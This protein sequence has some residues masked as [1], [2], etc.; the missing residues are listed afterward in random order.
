[1]LHRSYRIAQIGPKGV[2]G[3]TNPLA[4]GA[5]LSSKFYPFSKGWSFAHSAEP[6]DL[7]GLTSEGKTRYAVGTMSTFVSDRKRLTTAE[8]NARLPLWQRAEQYFQTFRDP[9]MKV[10]LAQVRLPEY[11]ED[12]A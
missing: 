1:M 5:D 3:K 8:R 7:K 10:S 12:A 6:G 9:K 11:E 4:R 2:G